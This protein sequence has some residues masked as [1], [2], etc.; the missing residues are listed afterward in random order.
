MTDLKTILE[1]LLDDLVAPNDIMSAWSTVPRETETPEY[2]DI[3]VY[4]PVDD[5]NIHWGEERMAKVKKTLAKHIHRDSYEETP[6]MLSFENNLD[7]VWPKEN[8][9]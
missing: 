7:N 9:D 6:G 1:G 5:E 2:I 3:I 8:D 4:R